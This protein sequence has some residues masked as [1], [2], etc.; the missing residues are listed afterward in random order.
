MLEP[1]PPVGLVV[2]P[3]TNLFPLSYSF[4]DPTDSDP[5]TSWIRVRMADFYKFLG[6]DK[7]LR[8]CPLTMVRSTKNRRLQP[9]SDY[10]TVFQDV[11]T[12]SGSRTYKYSEG[13]INLQLTVKGK[14]L[15]PD[16]DLIR[17][18]RRCDKSCKAV[19]KVESCTAADIEARMLRVMFTAFEADHEISCVPAGTTNRVKPLIG[20]HVALKSLSQMPTVRPKDIESSIVKVDLEYDY[21][22]EYIKGKDNVVGDILSRMKW[23]SM[24]TR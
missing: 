20:Q 6:A 2:Y 8:L 1:L 23:E 18:E 10:V 13:F 16:T 21:E 5:T 22:I 19:G 17:I 12:Q 3:A 7:R 24:T 11:T 4:L 15:S 14:A 9:F